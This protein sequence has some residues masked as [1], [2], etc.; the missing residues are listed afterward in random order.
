MLSRIF[1]I[2]SSFDRLLCENA[3]RS[4]YS[5]V[6]VGIIGTVAHC[7]YGTL[8]T[9]VTPLEHENVWLR[10]AGALSCF[11]LLIN[12]HWPTSWKKL[13]PW[14]WFAV[15]LYSLPFFATLQ[16]FSSNYSVLRSMLE[17]TMVFFVVIVFSQ[18]VLIVCNMVLGVTLAAWIAAL[19]LPNF[20]TLNHSVFFSVHLHLLIY[21][22]IAGMIFSRSNLRGLLA[23]EK[24]KVMT[25]LIGSIAHEMRS[26]MGQ[27]SQRMDAIGKRLPDHVVGA[28]TQTID[29]IDLEAIYAE[30]AKCK[31]AIERGTQVIT[32]TMDEISAK[33]IDSSKHR[34]L[35]MASVVNKALAEFSYRKASDKERISVVTNVDF[36]FLGDETRFIFTLFNLLKN[37]TYYFDKYPKARVTITLD[38][39]TV[40]VED[41]GPG[42][43]PE[44]FS[45]LFEAFH[46]EDKPGGT[47]LG[48]SFC[49]RTMLAFGG[50]IRCESVHGEFTRFVMQFPEVA[51]DEVSAHEQDVQRRGAS[52]FGGKRILDVEDTR[53][54]RQASKKVLIELGALVDEAED[55]NEA[56]AKLAAERHDAMLLDLCM[57]E[58][59]GYATAERVRRGAI[60]G[61]E[62]LTIVAHSSESPHAARVRLDRIG[63]KEFLS[64]GCSPLEL[65]E[66]LCRAHASSKSQAKTMEACAK[67][68]GKTILLVDD[69]D[70]SRKYVRT[71]LM[72]QGFQ[73]LEAPNGQ[74][75][76][77][78]LNDAS[79]HVDAVITDIHMPDLSGIEIAHTLRAR[80]RPRGTMPVI[81]LS[82]RSD[83]AMMSEAREA[84]INDFLIK[85]VQSIKLLE[86]LSRQLGI[87]IK[88][89]RVDALPTPQASAAVHA[90]I[91]VARLD[92]LRRLGLIKADLAHALEDMRTKF[93]QLA[94]YVAAND[95]GRAKTLMHALMGLAGHLGAR[96]FHDELRARYALMVETGQWPADGDWLLK[97]RQLFTDTDRLL[98]ARTGV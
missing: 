79:M 7:F 32:L 4:S 76:L 15:V 39:R 6:A 81:A 85:P 47:G 82:A 97:L 20:E 26:P 73:V 72:T 66:V 80:P 46:S 40:T 50:G 77:S 1:K 21:T 3:K 71:V 61:L 98:R 94:G 86:S 78:F 10:V 89:V 16:L 43:R 92:S 27:L 54:F 8:W 56:L 70:F 63:V 84:G 58:L 19:T 93:G 62:N 14:Y 30:I 23:Q 12:K 28:Q 68:S 87:A 57:P 67:H 53:H 45:R 60:P 36:V 91:D 83:E 17:V 11:G 48:L 64:K 69:E 34:Y 41:T 2:F 42:I 90:L 52:M 22:L 38:G 29:V 33:P 88:D 75:A 96:A 24:V 18:P 13:L 65:I 37:A 44:V 59:D 74:I 49:Q 9:Q 95:M 51:E 35:S 25:A 31:E 55:G 5:M